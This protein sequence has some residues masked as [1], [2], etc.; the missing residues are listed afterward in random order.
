MKPLLIT[1]ACLIFATYSIAQ[2]WEKHILEKA[3]IGNNNTVSTSDGGC[4][5][6][7]NYIESSGVNNCFLLKL[8]KNREIQ[9]FKTY[10]TLELEYFRYSIQTNDGGYAV[11]GYGQGGLIYYDNRSTLSRM[12]S[13]GNLLWAI[14]LPY[15]FNA[16][17]QQNDGTLLLAGSTPNPGENL[18][19]TCVNNSGIV[20]WTKIV[21]SS[22]KGSPQDIVYTKDN[23]LLILTRSWNEVSGLVKVNLKGNVLWSKTYIIKAMGLDKSKHKL[24]ATKDNGAIFCGGT[25]VKVNSM[26][27]VEWAN[28]YTGGYWHNQQIIESKYGGYIC[29]QSIDNGSQGNWNWHSTIFK[30][31]DAGEV[32]WSNL[33]GCNSI[34]HISENDS[35]FYLKGMFKSQIYI[36]KTDEKGWTGCEIDRNI[37]VSKTPIDYL[38][39]NQRVSFQAF[40]IPE[41][42]NIPFNMKNISAVFENTCCFYESKITINDTPC[43]GQYINLFAKGGPSFK[44]STGDTTEA[45]TVKLNNEAVIW[46]EASNSCRALRDS[47]KITPLKSP[48]LSVSLNE[49]F[50][51]NGDTIEL[52]IHRNA[53]YIYSPTGWLM[54]A[55]DSLYQYR[56]NN[57][58]LIIIHASISHHDSGSCSVSDTIY[59]IYYSIEESIKNIFDISLKPNP[60]RESIEIYFQDNQASKV[61]IRITSFNGTLL[62]HYKEQLLNN[63]FQK[64]I[65]L[66]QY[67][68]GI[69]FVELL[70]DNEK[71]VKKVI[72]IPE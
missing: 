67:G 71:I 55:S 52:I 18:I 57:C 24:I 38:V 51:C 28:H 54:K 66:S 49:P 32:E 35:G 64:I 40:H 30:I 46:V 69:Y 62:Y 9:W 37:K 60:T 10:G 3:G 45:I 8:S 25:Y 2:T 43:E 7:G 20:L 56:P 27:D 1:I 47:I 15:N 63:Q 36:A 61:E 12:N 42:G 16:L 50:K 14:T 6:A 31:S 17:I 41:T 72:V 4:L 11:I 68:S 39:N 33:L 23:N 70:T 22:T 59:T 44:W 19:L 29:S 26:G 5:L 58:G 48:T 21:N 13:E 34:H 53:D 65:N